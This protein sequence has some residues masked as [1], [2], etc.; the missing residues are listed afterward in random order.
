MFPP[1]TD[2]AAEA[3]FQP[4]GTPP[5]GGSAAQEAAQPAVPFASDARSSE[6]DAEDQGQG[7]DGVHMQASSASVDDSWM[8]VRLERHV[9]VCLGE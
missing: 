5:S 1:Q 8:G 2:P 6:K 9:C 3:L 4:Q 7:E